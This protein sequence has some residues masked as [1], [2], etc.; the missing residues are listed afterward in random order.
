MQ[1]SAIYGALFDRLSETEIDRCISLT[2][3]SLGLPVFRLPKSVPT[4]IYNSSVFDV[5][6]RRHNLSCP[7]KLPF[8]TLLITLCSWFILPSTI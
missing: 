7:R 5:K 3:P 2:R 4:D 1:N 8:V 6:K